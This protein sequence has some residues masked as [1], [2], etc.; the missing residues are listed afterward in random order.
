MSI[1]TG[2]FQGATVV[3]LCNAGHRVINATL[4]SG[5]VFKGEMNSDL[6]AKLRR[7][8]LKDRVSQLKARPK[9]AV[10]T[11]STSDLNVN[12]TLSRLCS[13]AQDVVAALERRAKSH[14]GAEDDGKVNRLGGFGRLYSDS[15]DLAQVAAIEAANEEEKSIAEASFAMKPTLGDVNITSIGNPGSAMSPDTWLALSTTQPDSGLGIHDTQNIDMTLSSVE[16]GTSAQFRDLVENSLGGGALLDTDGLMDACELLREIERDDLEVLVSSNR[17]DGGA[18]QPVTGTVDLPGGLEPFSEQPTPVATESER[19]AVMFNG[20]DDLSASRGPQD[21]RRTW[22]EEHDGNGST[23]SAGG[24]GMDSESGSG[25]RGEPALKRSRTRTDGRDK[26]ETLTEEEK[27]EIRKKRNREAAARSNLKR[28]IRNESV[29]RELAKLTQ[30]AVRLRVQETMLRD[31][32]TRLRN[33][34]RAAK[35]PFLTG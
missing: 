35:I 26:K 22:D 32:N 28:K 25:N 23:D 30:Q 19:A 14:A 33:A 7:L 12:G 9:R 29:R 1:Y 18:I 16:P 2:F 27:A 34:L 5:S 4:Q 17:A 6:I 20:T 21:Q 3:R 13:D 11:P 15:E 8:A 24:G 31:E 10:A